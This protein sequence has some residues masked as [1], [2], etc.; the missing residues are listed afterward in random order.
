M[1][2]RINQSLLIIAFLYLTIHFHPYTIEKLKYKEYIQKCKQKDFINQEFNVEQEYIFLSICLP[3][4]NMEKYIESS[5]LSLIHQTFQFFEIIIINDNS[6]DGTL[7]IVKQIQ[8]KDKRIKL[9][10]HSKNLGVYASRADS[11]FNSKGK[12]ILLMD[13]DD[14][15]FNQELLQEL[16][17]YYIK[18]NIDIIEFLVYHQKEGRNN[19]IFPKDHTLSHFHNFQNKIIYQP[20]LSEI[21][22]YKP[23]TK[24]Y[25][26]IIC[27]TIWNKIIKKEILI[28]SINYLNNDYFKNQFLIAADD[29]PLNILSLQFANNY[30]NI[31]IP[32]YLYN[33][34]DNGMSNY[35]E[36]NSKHNIILS[37]NFLLYF[38]FLY[39]YTI[40]FSKDINF[41]LYDFE[42]F[43]YYLLQLKTFNA[44]EY[45]PIVIR[46]LED[47]N[48]RDISEYFKIF[49]NKLIEYFSK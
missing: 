30:T 46:F 49:V 42:D 3:V 4:Y 43:S 25:S 13:P 10:N 22:F 19:I 6:N 14:I 35:K 11:I 39:K 40:N 32:G 12:Y 16:Y 36:G 24:Q 5:L 18:Y 41:F 27:R 26:S 45:I 21:I 37:Y 28:N 44:S 17:A 20:D 48:K 23:D 47:I 2:K 38:K 1:F 29:T 9:V 34:R 7:N 8:E 15:I 31:N 33:L